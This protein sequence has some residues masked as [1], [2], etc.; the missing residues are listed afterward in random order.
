MAVAENTQE[1]ALE[2][3]FRQSTLLVLSALFIWARYLAPD[4]R[5]AFW[6]IVIV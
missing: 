5:K 3:L 6:Y 2:T 4:G 1:L